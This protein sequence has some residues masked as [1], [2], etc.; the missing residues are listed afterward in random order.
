MINLEFLKNYVNTNLSIKINI[1]ITNLINFKIIIFFIKLI[2]DIP[3]IKNLFFNQNNTECNTTILNIIEIIKNFII[4]LHTKLK[5]NSITI[6][7]N[8]FKK[9]DEQSSKKNGFLKR[10][11]EVCR[12][13][14]GLKT[15]SYDTN[16]AYLQ[17]DMDIFSNY[18][19]NLKILCETN[20]DFIFNI[21]NILINFLLDNIPYDNFNNK[22]LL[23]FYQ[24][25]KFEHIPNNNTFIEDILYNICIMIPNQNVPQI[26]KKSTIESDKS[27]DLK[28][29]T[30][31]QKEYYKKTIYLILSKLF[32][33]YDNNIYADQSNVDNKLNFI[34]YLEKIF[35][36]LNNLPVFIKHKFGIDIIL[37]FILELLKNFNNGINKDV[38]KDSTAGI[39][40]YIK[41]IISKFSPDFCTNGSS[42]IL[43][44]RPTN[45]RHI[46]LPPISHPLSPTNPNLML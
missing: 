5:I 14:R 4:S 12:N 32:L 44:S 1:I 7:I 15:C 35:D 8:T 10:F 20:Y 22:L 37:E 33:Y 29:L 34:T 16:D 27:D 19:S 43:L 2:S 17:K 26:C 36:T 31:L 18:L 13:I 42:Q 28:K 3:F 24:L 40:D 9:I 23:K 11:V 46:R 39:I 30:D 25:I 38:N 6:D 45:N 41:S 21:I